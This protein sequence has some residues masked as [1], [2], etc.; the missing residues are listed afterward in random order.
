[1]KNK[2]KVQL[3]FFV[4]FI[5]RYFPSRKIIKKRAPDGDAINMIVNDTTTSK[6]DPIDDQERSNLTNRKTES[7]CVMN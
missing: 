4:W 2:N 6:F 1:M 7:T 3:F 5:S